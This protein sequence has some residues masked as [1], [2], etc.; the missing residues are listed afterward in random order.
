MACANCGTGELT[1]YPETAQRV[2]YLGLTVLATVVLYYELYIQGAVATKIIADVPLQ[3][4]VRSCSCSVVGNALGAFASLAA[5]LADRWGRANLV[6]G[7]P[8]ADRR[9]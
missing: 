5:G 8:A 2:L 7:R 1:R 9:C 4:H 3:L 6:V